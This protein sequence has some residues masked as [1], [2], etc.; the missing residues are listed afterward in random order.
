MKNEPWRGDPS[1]RVR[2]LEAR[3][4]AGKRARAA[5]EARNAALRSCNDRAN[6]DVHMIACRCREAIE[7]MEKWRTMAYALSFFAALAAVS[8]LVFALRP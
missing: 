1:A 4:A 3:L 5:L 2:H 7:D 8:A 6:D